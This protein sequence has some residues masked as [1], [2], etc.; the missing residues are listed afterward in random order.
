MAMADI[1][2]KPA[3]AKIPERKKKRGCWDFGFLAGFWWSTDKKGQ[4][5]GFFSSFF[6]AKIGCEVVCAQKQPQS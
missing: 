1:F 3:F 6:S 2:E 5:A 4:K